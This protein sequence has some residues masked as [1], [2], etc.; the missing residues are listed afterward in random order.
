MP[1]KEAAESLIDTA[2]TEQAMDKSYNNNAK[3]EEE[4]I[5]EQP[6]R[7][8]RVKDEVMLSRAAELHHVG[9]HHQ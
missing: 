4:M 3:K 2:K 5:S 7:E 6:K 1:K 8:Y 9:A